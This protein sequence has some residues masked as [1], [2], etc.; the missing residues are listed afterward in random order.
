[1]LANLWGGYH[2]LDI[3]SYRGDDSKLIPKKVDC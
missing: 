2:H 1:M 3:S